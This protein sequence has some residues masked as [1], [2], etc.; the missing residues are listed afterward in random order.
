LPVQQ[1]RLF[2]NAK[3]VFEHVVDLLDGRQSKSCAK[4]S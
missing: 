3:N 4:S 1:Q 2:M